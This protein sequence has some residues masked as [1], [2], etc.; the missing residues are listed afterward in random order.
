MKNIIIAVVMVAIGVAGALLYVKSRKAE[1]EPAV[2]APSPDVS[3]MHTDAASLAAAPP[4]ARHGIP[5]SMCAFCHPELIEKL[6]WCNGHGVPEAF[7]TR[8]SPILIAAFKV[9]NDWCAEHNL[10]ESQC[11]ICK[12]EGPTG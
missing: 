7:C 6:G 1:P 5:E 11:A 8:C 4:C 10:P 2:G 12:G 9:E 3:P